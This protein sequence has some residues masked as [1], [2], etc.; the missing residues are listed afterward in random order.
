M[1]HQFQRNCSTQQQQQQYQGIKSP[2]SG[3]QVKVVRTMTSQ[4]L[5]VLDVWSSASIIQL[6]LT[7]AGRSHQFNRSLDVSL[8]VSMINIAIGAL[9]RKLVSIGT[10]EIVRFHSQIIKWNLYFVQLVRKQL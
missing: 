7:A 9:I 10:T 2:V 3:R 8:F 6:Y 5:V 1:F 4:S